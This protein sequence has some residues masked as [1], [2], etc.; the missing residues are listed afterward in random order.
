MKL[1]I[2]YDSSPESKAAL[3][4]LKHAGLPPSGEAILLSIADF[5][6]P[7]AVTESPYA[8]NVLPVLEAREFAEQRRDALLEEARTAAILLKE[9]L[10]G[11]TIHGEA[12]V[13]T[14]ARGLLQR[15]AE[16]N[17]DLLCVGAP[18]HSRLERLFF[19]SNSQKVLSHA[20]CSVRIGRTGPESGPLR[21]LLAMDGS[22]D[23]HAAAAVVAARRWP[24]GTEVSVAAVRDSRFVAFAG[25]VIDPVYNEPEGGMLTGTAD[26]L[27]AAGLK[28]STDILDG[29][30]AAALLAKAAEWNAHCVFAG[31]GGFG[32]LD[33]L[34][35][36]SVSAAL[37]ARAPCSVEIVRRASAGK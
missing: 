36:G 9:D 20:T 15:A 14:P 6:I 10:P 17:P 18:H 16:W 31:A 22:P 2:G 25:A 27:S 37:A 26:K 19:G 34:L 11:W 21:L 4:D 3:R 12:V 29:R 13:D 1:L 5:F 28:V 24:E 30:P 23:A 33:R 35:L 8:L 7:P 32:A